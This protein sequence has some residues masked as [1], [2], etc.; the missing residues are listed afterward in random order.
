MAA[1]EDSGSAA[2]GV[3]LG[4][5]DDGRRR[6]RVSATAGAA[7]SAP[8]AAAPA[9]VRG[10]TRQVADLL[11]PILVFVGVLVLWEVDRRRRSTSRRSS[12]RRRSPS[13]RR[14][15]RELGRRDLRDPA[16]GAGDALRGARRARHR[17][18]G[19]R[20]WSRSRR[21]AGLVARDALMPLAIAAGAVPIIAFAP[22]MNN[23]FGVLSPLSKMMMAAVLVFFPVM[24]NVTRGLVQVEPSALELMRSYA[25]SEGAIAAQGPHPQ[26]AAVLLHGAEGRHDAQ[27]HRG[28]RRRVLRRLV[29]RPR[30]GHRPGRERAALR[31]HV[32]SGRH[33]GGHR[34]RALPRRGGR[35]A[36]GHP[37]ARLDAE[38]ASRRG[39]VR[40]SP[41]VECRRRSH[42][43]GWSPEIR[44]AGRDGQLPRSR[45]AGAAS[46]STAHERRGAVSP[47]VPAASA[48]ASAA[49]DRVGKCSGKS[50]T[51]PGGRG[52]D[53]Q[54]AAPVGPAGPVR[55]LLRGRGAGLLRGREPDV[56]I[57]AA[58]RTI[59]PQTVGS[60]DGPEFTIAW[61]PKVLEAREVAGADLVDIA[62]IFQRSGTLSVSWKDLEHHQARASSRAR[63][64]AS[65]TS[66]TSTR[67]RPAPRR[68]GLE[69]GDRLHRRSSSRST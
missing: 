55:R 54:P 6:G 17:D 28:D 60:A 49:A 66:A 41:A 48:P 45:R 26:R 32:G 10:R 13:S 18:G 34:H 20:R 43:H 64:S 31:R 29:A 9:A 56:T 46:S 24:V 65:G 7:P 59:I 50:G 27:P 36:P 11:P 12:S 14:S 68:S 51:E 5:P 30:P 25:A 3:G 19:G 16:V 44:R 15:G 67:S 8:A 52:S 57:V 47:P 69:Q 42:A 63:R 21:R 39:P 2:S 4:A 35:R 61:V 40:P 62:Q 23:W 37:V 53:G 1:T 22:L 58:A 38:P 33:R